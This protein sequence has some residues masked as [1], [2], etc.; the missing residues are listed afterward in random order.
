MRR[1]KDPNLYGRDN[2]GDADWPDFVVKEGLW[3]GRKLFDLY[4]EAETPY[5]W[6]A[7]IFA[8]AEK[9]GVPLFSSPFD[10][11][12]ID[13]LVSLDTKIFKNRIARNG[14]YGRSSLNTRPKPVVRLSCQ[15][16]W[17]CLKRWMRCS[18]APAQASSRFCCYTAFL[19]IQPSLRM[20]QSAILP[21]WQRATNAAS[22]CQTTHSGQRPL[23]LLLGMHAPFIEKHFAFC[24][25]IAVVWIVRFLWN[26]PRCVALLTMWQLPMPRLVVVRTL[27][28]RTMS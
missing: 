5:E 9:I 11:T 16:A 28:S 3:G 10:E 18:R 4:K 14:R 27:R 13:L 2:I 7:D 19:H 21:F 26:P 15:S 22:G 6:H 23:S 20:P 1:H 17:H 25:V 12:A 24:T 8:H